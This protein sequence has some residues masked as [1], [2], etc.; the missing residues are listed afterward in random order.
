MRMLLDIFSQT[1]RTLWAHKLRSF[2]TMFGIAWGVFSL[3]LLVGAGEG[4]RTGNKKQLDTIGENIMFLFGGR[5]P[6]TQ[7]SHTSSRTFQVTYTDYLS[8]KNRAREVRYVTPV[9]IRG[10][11]RMNY[12][13]QSTNGQILGV[14]PNYNKLR[15]MPI[16]EGRW[17][18]ENDDSDHH[19][20]VVLGNELYNNLFG[21]KRAIGQTVLLNGY[22]FVVVGTCKKMRGESSATDMR[23]FC[24][25]PTSPTRPI[26]SPTSTISPRTRTATWKRDARC[27]CWSARTTATSIPTWTTT[28]STGTPS[29]SFAPRARSS[30]P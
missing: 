10:D 19:Y 29:I 2:L 15:F 8:I 25:T 16:Q 6:A 28:G 11:M 18:D 23:A 14:T 20:V 17:L 12:D 26:P 27:A 13:S 9:L 4:F 7:G 5:I 30:T 1:L 3:L 22:R 21:S 24:R